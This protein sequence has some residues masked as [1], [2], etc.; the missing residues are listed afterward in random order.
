MLI[1]KGKD[2]YKGGA[3]YGAS[4]GRNQTNEGIY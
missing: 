2:L 1:E 3:G 4:G